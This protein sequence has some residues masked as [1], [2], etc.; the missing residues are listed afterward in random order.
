MSEVHG[1]K[2]SAMRSGGWLPAAEVLEAWLHDF[3]VKSEASPA[4][5]H[6]VI[7]EFADLIADDPIVRMYCTNMIAQAP[8]GRQYRSHHL[9]SLDQML[10]LMNAVL[11]YAPE[12]DTSA[13]VGC[14]LDAILDWSMGTP[15]GFAAFRH[16]PI[17]AM[18]KK[19][20]GVWC[21]FLRSE[22]SL[23]VIND[24]PKGW[25]CDQARALTR[26]ADFEH[27]PDD[28]YWG[29]VSWNDFFT[30]RF[31]PGARPVAAPDDTSI[32][33]NACEST[34][35]NVARHVKRQDEFWI[36]S[37]PYSLRDMLAGDPRAADFA[38]G[39]VY[40]A[41]LSAFNYHRWHS[42]VSGTILKALNVEG[43]YF[44]EAEAEGEDPLGPNN[45]QGYIAHVAARAIIHIEAD[46]PAIG[47]MA[48]VPVGMGEI[49]SCVVDPRIKPNARVSKG[50]ELGYFQYGGST[51]CL[52]FRP[53]AVGAFA[54][55]AIP[56]PFNPDPP[57]LLANSFLASAQ[58]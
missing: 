57:L 13:F 42:P 22:A 2:K 43:T 8:R 3:A 19:I 40:Q 34:P 6:P 55:G 51:H 31:K 18:L 49:S 29:F 35:Y 37:Q 4:H 21:Q 5:R 45:S 44:S 1:A 58:R 15:A 12:F 32:I 24:S 53:E 23:Y 10:S 17:N 11:T 48:V 7:E 20:L 14:P 33:V 50:D 27:D 39:T 16:P 28:R 54:L 30:R 52:V 36:K 25:K 9:T 47:H 38:G 41:Y 46:D 26:M 56:Q